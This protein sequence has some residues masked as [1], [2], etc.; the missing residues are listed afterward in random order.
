MTGC[1]KPPFVGGRVTGLKLTQ[2]TWY[3]HELFEKNAYV[4]V[5]EMAVLYHSIY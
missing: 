5:E 3:L 4:C 2:A 1:V